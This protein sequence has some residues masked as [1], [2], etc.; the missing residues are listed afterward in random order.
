MGDR[1]FLSEAPQECEGCEGV[2]LVSISRQEWTRQS[3]SQFH[4]RLTMEQGRGVDF[5]SGLPSSPHP[6]N[7][8]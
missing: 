1:G 3:A 4:E 7:R 8:C 2:D 5:L 6:S